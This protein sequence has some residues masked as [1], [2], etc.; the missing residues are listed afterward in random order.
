M[1]EAPFQEKE[2]F[3]LSGMVLISSHGQG[4]GREDLQRAIL[5]DG[6]YNSKTPPSETSALIPETLKMKRYY[7][8]IICQVGSE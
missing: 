1:V 3:H 7:V 5:D 4:D 8:N 6:I 2:E